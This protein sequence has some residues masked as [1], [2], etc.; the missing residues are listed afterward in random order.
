M[1]TIIATVLDNKII[2]GINGPRNAWNIH[3]YGHI[4]FAYLCFRAFYCPRNNRYDYY[5]LPCLFLL[6]LFGMLVNNHRKS[7]TEFLLNLSF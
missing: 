4:L 5:Y 1:L 6:L 7:E 2:L 3:L